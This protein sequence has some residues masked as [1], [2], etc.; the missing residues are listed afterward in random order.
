MAARLNG[1]HPTRNTSGLSGRG[2]PVSTGGSDPWTRPSDWLTLP[3]VT[4]SDQKFVGLHAVYPEGNFVALTAAGDY[5]VDW[6]DGVVENFSANVVAEH[7]YNYS[8][9]D[10]SNTTLSSRGYK[11]AII[12]ITPQSGQNLTVLN[13]HQRHSTLSVA[14]SSGFLDIALSSEFLTD[15][16]IGVAT[17]GSTTQNIRFADL[18]QVNIVRSDLRTLEHLFL[19]CYSLQSVIGI[20]TSTKSASTLSVT[21]TDAGDL[22]TSVAHGLRN[23]DTVILLSLTSTTGIT[24]G[25]R[26]FVISATTDTFQLSSTYGGSAIAL[27]TDGSGTLVGGTSMANMFNNCVSLTTIP[28]LNTTSVSTMNN[29]FSGCR[30]MTS[31]PL[32]NTESVIIMSGMFNACSI[33][34]TVP[35]FNTASVIYMGSMFFGCSGLKTV[36][37]FNTASVITMSN[38]FNACSILETVPLF[39]TA[40]VTIVNDMFNSCYKLKTVPLFNTASVTTMSQMF[41]NCYSLTTVPLFDTSSVTNTNS[42]FNYCYSLTS[43]PL[44]N[45]ASVTTMVQMFNNCYSL[46]SVPA[47]ITTAVTTSPNFS[48]MFNNC[49]SLTRIQAK[50][51]NYTFSVANCKLSATAL[52]EIYTNLPTVTGQT[53]T[54]TGNYGT[55]SDDPTIATAKGW[56]VTG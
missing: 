30:N 35:L 4:E 22:V 36:P 18:E 5:T 38:M 7:E 13:L 34:E 55:S 15:L 31:V 32:F 45:T 56:T 25:I 53:I 52:N 26:Y 1:A 2:L 29:M 19:N 16:R 10:T 40:S 21:F 37:L 46:T 50:N 3:T 39:N 54:V 41:N 47:L 20:S 24:A 27:T 49:N 43:V 11:Q 8:T 44:F 6:G 17:P 42:M 33:L 9:Y 14:Y 28:L 48:G 51:F 12:T 23:G